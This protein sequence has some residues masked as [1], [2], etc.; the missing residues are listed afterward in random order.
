M[1][2]LCRVKK[3]LTMLLMASM[4]VCSLTDRQDL[5]RVTQLL[6]MERTKESF[7]ELVTRSSEEL[8][9]LRN[10]EMAMWSSK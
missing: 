4:L 10:L 1:L 8:M 2:H 6:D 9:R 5:E 3:C 7:Q